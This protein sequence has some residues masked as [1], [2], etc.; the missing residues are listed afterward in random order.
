MKIKTKLGVD[1]GMMA[2]IPCAL[3][4]DN[5]KA[6]TDVLEDTQR[7]NIVDVDGLAVV[8]TIEKAIRCFFYLSTDGYVSNL[9]L[10]N[11]YNRPN[12]SSLL[13]SFLLLPGTYLL[14]DPCYVTKDERY[15]EIC[16]A[17]LPGFKD[18]KDLNIHNTI[19][20]ITIDEKL[21]IVVESGMGDG[22]YPA[23]VEIDSKEKGQ[24][25]RVYIKVEFLEQNDHELADSAM[26]EYYHDDLEQDEP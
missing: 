4:Q 21:V 14:A 12:Q 25:D 2:I 17:L 6:I 26:W 5:Y 3:Y 22:L 13:S 8:F 10:T 1:A 24:R 19:A 16:N 11:N 18:N 20:I 15:E 9:V 7:A 23:I